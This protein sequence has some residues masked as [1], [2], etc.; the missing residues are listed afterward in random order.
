MIHIPIEC[1]TKNTIKANVWGNLLLSHLWSGNRQVIPYFILTDITI[2]NHSSRYQPAL[3]NSNQ[4]EI[5]FAKHRMFLNNLT[6]FINLS[7]Q[8]FKDGS[9]SLIIFSNNNTLC[10]KCLSL[11]LANLFNDLN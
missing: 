5:R 10:V 1:L 8:R 6:S 3:T 2:L 9:E 7:L 4:I 11:S